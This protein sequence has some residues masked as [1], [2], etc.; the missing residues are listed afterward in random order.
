MR[1]V[2]WI[3]KHKLLMCSLFSPK[4]K[5]P[6]AYD[7]AE[8]KLWVDAWAISKIWEVLLIKRSY[9]FP[10]L[11][12]LA[13]AAGAYIFKIGHKRNWK[14][15]LDIP[16]RTRKK[17]NGFSSRALTEAKNFLG[18]N[19]RFCIFLFDDSANQLAVQIKIHRNTMLKKK[20]SW[21]P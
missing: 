6:L 4:I 1:C 3:C 14:L 17:S 11:I 19:W 16:N 5:E 8:Y 12:V 13:A 21:L 15:E 20:R 18:S 7:I 2:W 10:L 9:M